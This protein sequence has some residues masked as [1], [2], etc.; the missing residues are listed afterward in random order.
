MSWV[1]GVD[2]T[3]FRGIAKCEIQGFAQVNVLIG[4]N[5][6][7]KSSVLEAIT[8]T[9]CFGP[10]FQGANKEVRG[11]P[12]MQLWAASRNEPQHWSEDLVKKRADKARVSVHGAVSNRTWSL[13]LGGSPMAVPK[14]SIWREERVGLFLPAD[15]NNKDIEIQLWREVFGSRGDRRIAEHLGAA[16]EMEI[17]SLNMVGDTLMVGLPHEGISIDGQGLGVRTAVRM[18]ILAELSSGGGLVIEEPEC[19][20]HPAALGSLA[21]ALTAQAVTGNTQLFI[22]THSAECVRAFAE[23]AADTKGEPNTWAFAAWFLERDAG[24]LVKPTKLTKETVLDFGAGGT[25]VRCL[26]EFR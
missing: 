17:D 20:F 25:D 26:D 16:F 10:N 19:H 2:I 15:A 8:R 23:A 21:K 13:T 14:D 1:D 24:G 12:I 5:N 9:F 3:D 6:C 22:T 4:R 11:R 18:M 7:G